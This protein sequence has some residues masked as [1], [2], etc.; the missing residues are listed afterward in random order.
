MDQ[1]ISWRRTLH[2]VRL[3]NTLDHAEWDGSIP[4]PQCCQTMAAAV[5]MGDCPVVYEP[6]FRRWE[7]RQHYHRMFH[8][9]Q[10]EFCPWCGTRLPRDLGD[11]WTNRVEALGF[12]N[13]G[14]YSEIPGLP[15]DFKTDRWWKHE[16]L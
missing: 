14:H 10:L 9:W 15:D 8:D 2:V 7:I 13:G 3:R 1:L 11:E 12:T 5:A 16:R 4:E 6:V